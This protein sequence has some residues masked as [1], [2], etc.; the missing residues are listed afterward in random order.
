MVVKTDEADLVGRAGTSLD[1]RA[2]AAFDPET[3]Q[4]KWF[5][6][7]QNLAH[8]GNPD[9]GQYYHQL[10]FFTPDGSKVLASQY[11]E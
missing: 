1:T 4:Y 10:V 8:D 11:I 3:D 7:F 2:F 5:K 6:V 9:V